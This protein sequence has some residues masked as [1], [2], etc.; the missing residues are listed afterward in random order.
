M[1]NTPVR[2]SW[3]CE[4]HPCLRMEDRQIPKSA[5]ASD[6][7]LG[8]VVFS[9]NRGTSEE[10]LQVLGGREEPLRWVYIEPKVDRYR[11]PS[12]WVSYGFWS[13]DAQEWTLGRSQVGRPCNE[14]SDR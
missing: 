6:L 13:K 5:A 3:G 2:V 8:E 14:E 9:R 4:Y 12:S 1:Y 7:V 11:I 10:T